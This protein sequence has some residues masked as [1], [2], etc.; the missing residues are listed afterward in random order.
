M[1]SSTDKKGKACI[2]AKKQAQKGKASA[3]F[4]YFIIIAVVILIVAWKSGAFE[5]L[6]A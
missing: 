3:G 5:M 6:M 4:I 1:S 2:N